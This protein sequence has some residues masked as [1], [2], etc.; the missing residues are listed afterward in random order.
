MLALNWFITLLYVTMAD[1]V[2]PLAL[3]V[4]LLGELTAVSLAEAPAL[5]PVAVFMVYQL[6]GHVGIK[7]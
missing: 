5:M 1:K 3:T 7:Q 2:L 6:A 4:V